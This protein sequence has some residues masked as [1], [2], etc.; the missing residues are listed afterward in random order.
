VKPSGYGPINQIAFIVPNID[1]GI[2][3]WTQTMRVGPFFKFPKIVFEEADYRGQPQVPDF[4]AAIAYSGELM[5]ELIRPVGQSIFKEFA[6]RGGTGVQHIAAFADDFSLASQTLEKR[7]GKR[8]QGGRFA[9]GSRIGYF[10]MGGAEPAIIEIAFLSPAVLGLFGTIKA[11]GATWDG[12]TA[13][14]SF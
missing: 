1:A 2:A 8:I 4:E 6:D 12:E 7:G 14:V 11:A 3:H 9:D 13:T 5:I 10:D